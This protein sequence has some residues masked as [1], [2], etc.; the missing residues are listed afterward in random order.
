MN[1]LYRK[2]PYV[3][4]NNGHNSNAVNGNGTGDVDANG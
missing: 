3:A 2:K 1:L 4:N